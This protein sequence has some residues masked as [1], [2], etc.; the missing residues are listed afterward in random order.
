MW[1]Y[2]FGPNPDTRMWRS[3]WISTG[4]GETPTR[5]LRARCSGDRTSAA[6]EPHCYMGVM[7]IMLP[8]SWSW[9]REGRKWYRYSPVGWISQGHPRDTSLIRSAT[10]CMWMRWFHWWF[11][12][13]WWSGT[14][15]SSEG[16]RSVE[17]SWCSLHCGIA[18]SDPDHWG[19]V[20]ECMR[21]ASYL[22][23]SV[24]LAESFV[25]TQTRAA[26]SSLFFLRSKAK[27]A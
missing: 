4:R 16:H 7:G 9:R 17:E 3:T 14:P 19:V 21:P 20:Q 24:L 1:D 25:A 2:L 10:S 15:G 5:N 13:C 27:S 6:V 26:L 18:N 22:G 11:R 23:G 12:S 8:W